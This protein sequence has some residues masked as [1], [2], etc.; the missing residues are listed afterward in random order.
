MW[1]ASSRSEKRGDDLSLFCG[2]KLPAPYIHGKLFMLVRYQTPHPNYAHQLFV[3]PSKHVH[4]LK[5]G[6]LKWQSKAMEVKL[7][8]VSSADREHVVYFLL[9]DHC[10]AAFYAEVHLGRSLPSVKDFLG[11]AWRK[12]ENHFFHG[13]PVVAVVPKTV[14]QLDPEISAFIESCG[15]EQVEPESGFQAGVHQIRNFEKAFVNSLSFYADATIADVAKLSEKTMRWLNDSLLPRA[16]ATRR[17][18]W[19]RGVDQSGVL[20]ML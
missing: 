9:A 5:D 16:G 13:L 11:R 3:T 4:V 2:C 15:V 7:Q 8:G 19:E 1:N 17:Q 6:R 12:K 18:V 14:T 10:S 20:V